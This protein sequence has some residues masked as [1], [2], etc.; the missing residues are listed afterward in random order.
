M[1][2]DKALDGDDTWATAY[3]VCSFSNSNGQAN[4]NMHRVLHKFWLIM[5]LF[6]C[7]CVVLSGV[8]FTYHRDTF[9]WPSVSL[10]FLIAY[11]IK[12][13]TLGEYYYMTRSYILGN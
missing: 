1:P 2:A 9:L 4:F 8:G 10:T 3:A 7:T 12:S 5:T 6:L 13:G 11:L